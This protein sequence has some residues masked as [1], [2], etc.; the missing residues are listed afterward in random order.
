MDLSY[1]KREKLKS[2]KIIDQL[3]VEGK[4][5]THF[6][7]KLIYLETPLPEGL[8]LQVGVAVSKK[9]FKNAVKRNRVKRLLRESYR[10]HKN[11]VTDHSKSSYAFLILYLG[12]KMPTH[13]VV[14]KQLQYLLDKFNAQENA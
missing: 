12:K 10:V 8:K 3:F 1:P 2:K 11:K 14:D 13:A 6:P 7:L 5:I 4:S 9:R